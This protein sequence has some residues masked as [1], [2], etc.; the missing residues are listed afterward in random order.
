M[1]HINTHRL[2]KE[3]A[4]DLEHG[5]DHLDLASCVLISGKYFKLHS[6]IVNSSILVSQLLVKCLHRSGA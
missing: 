4:M 6:D 2:R 5:L 3:S 1:C